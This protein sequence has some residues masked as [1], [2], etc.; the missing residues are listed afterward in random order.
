MHEPVKA[1]HDHRSETVQID[2]DNE[3]INFIHADA[4]RESCASIKKQYP[5]DV[6][7]QSHKELVHTKRVRCR[8]KI[9]SNLSSNYKYVSA[10]VN[11]G[12]D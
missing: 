12:L 4:K 1:L 7:A 9:S 11:F 10:F 2:F 3:P 6:T 8:Y 5:T